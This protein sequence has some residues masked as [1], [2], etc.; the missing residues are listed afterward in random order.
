MIIIP[1]SPTPES[2]SRNDSPFGVTRYLYISEAVAELIILS[3]PFLCT[4]I[5]FLIHSVLGSL[6]ILV[7]DMV[8]TPEA[9]IA[10]VFSSELELA[11]SLI[12]L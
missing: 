9:N 12:K 8:S 11:R 5:I 4:R 7:S 3:G 2:K 10:L 6:I 1:L